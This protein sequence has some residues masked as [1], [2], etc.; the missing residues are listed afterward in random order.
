MSNRPNRFGGILR[1]VVGVGIVLVTVSIYAVDLLDQVVIE[2][3]AAENL[4]NEFVRAAGSVSRI[5]SNAGDDIHDVSALR[6]AF[7][8]IFEL[9]PGI[10]HLE[11]FDLTADSHRLVL[12][13]HPQNLL[14]PLGAQEWTDVFSGK[15]VATFDGSANDRAWLITAPIVIDGRV[16]GALRGRFSQ[17]KYDRLILKEGQVT[18]VAAVTAVA[19]TSVVFLLLIRVKVHRPLSTLVRAMRHVEAGDLTCEAPAAGP[20][21]IREIA[22]Q[23]NRMLRRIREEVTIKERLVAEI[24]ALNDSL[25]ARVAEA[26][27]ELRRT[28]MRLLA[29]QVQAERTEKLAA[30][31]ELS[32]VVAHELGN[33]LNA[34]GGQVQL[35][36]AG[37]APHE[38]PRLK[39]IQAELQRMV[40]A[41]QHIL[42]STRVTVLPGPV[43]LGAVIREVLALIEPGLPAN[44]ITVKTELLPGLPSVLGDARGLHGIVFNL[45]AN[46]VQ[47]MPRGGELEIKTMQVV[48]G[49]TEGLVILNGTQEL[50]HGAAR[51]VIRDTGHGIAS[52]DLG[53]VFEPFFTTR[54][55]EGGTGLG[56]AICRRIISNYGGRLAVLSAPSQGTT[57]TIDLPI[58]KEEPPSRGTPSVC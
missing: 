22:G 3:T 58:W 39:I 41:I 6:E 46:A 30:L 43:D 10:R 50:E 28:N 2:T 52:K 57:F 26:T 19:I 49:R 51:L 21:D 27:A 23:L 48:D 7:Q 53:N 12:S 31:G 13:S 56:L 34:I 25:Q 37:S 36:L 47:A 40:G 5:V 35:L 45:V 32:A 20:S 24:R 11:V 29:A 14:A 42:N 9:R 55:G 44:L 15:T 54:Q 1:W 33:P 16:A 18:K 4:R 17:W 38:T 8:D